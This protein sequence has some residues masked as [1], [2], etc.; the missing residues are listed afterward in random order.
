MTQKTFVAMALLCS[1][2]FAQSADISFFSTNATW[3]WLR[4][5]AEASSPDISS[6]RSNSF[7]DAAFADAPAPFWYGDVQP[8][9]TQLTDML[10]SYS[11]IFLRRT[12]VVT[13]VAE[14]SALRFGARVDDGYVV[15]INGNERLRVNVTGVAGD[16][17]TITTLAANA[18][19]PV[20]FDSYTFGSLGSYLVNGTNTIAIQ[21]FNTSLGSSDLVFDCSLDGV[22]IDTNPPVILSVTPPPGSS[23]NTLTQVVVQFSEPITSLSADDLNIS[24]V[25]ATAVS[26]S[27]N[28][29]T[30]TFAQPPAGTV[31]M[32]WTAGHSIT[33]LATPGNPFNEFAPGATWNYTLVDNVPPVIS[34]LFPGAD[35]TV[36]TLGQIQ[37]TFSETV[38]GVNA[39]DLLIN[40]SP[41]TNLVVLLNSVYLF[42]FPLQPSG[43][44]SV[45]WAGGHGIADVAA[46]PNAFAGGAWNYTVDPNANVSGVIINEINVSNQ[47][48]ARDENGEEQDWIELYNSG[49][50]A[51][52]LA[53]WSLSDDE[54]EPGRWVFPTRTMLP[55][56]YLVV[57]ASAKDRRAPT[58]TN[59]F[60]TNFKLAGDGEFLGLFTPDSPRQLASGFSPEFPEQRNDISYGRD[61]D[62]NYRYFSTPTFN[63][64]NGV[65]TVNGVVSRVHFS[66]ERG[67]FT[68]AFPLVLS[69][70]TRGATIRYTLDGS[71]PT[72]LRGI[73]Y[74]GPI[75]VNNSLFIRAGAFHED[76]L[77]SKITSHSFLF[78]QSAAIRSLP[79]LSI[80]TATNNLIGTNGIIGMYGGTG[81]PNNAWTPVNPGDFHNPTKKGIEWEKPNSVEYILPGDNSG[82][83]IDCG[84]R[85]QGSDWT[86]PRYQAGDKFS[87]RLYFRG[88]Y[89]PGDL[90]YQWFTDGIV[91]EFDQI[92]LRAGHN[93][94]S[95]PFLRDEL[96]RQLHA[97]MGQ[98]AVHGNWV[99]FF[100]NGVYKGYYN[101]C[102]RV[103]EG[104]LQSWHGGSN[105]W[106]V[107]TVG[108]VSQGDGDTVD[109]TSLR[110]YI[111]TQDA[112]QPAV[113]NEVLR[114]M[115]VANFID[116]LLVNTYAATWD[117][118]HNNWRAARERVP[119]GKWRF[120]VWD[121]EGAFGEFD[122]NNANSDSF[123]N[124]SINANGVTSPLLNGTAEI[125]VFYTRLRNSAEFRLMWADRV[126]KH[127]F[128]GGAM[129]DTNITQR[130]LQ[131][132]GELSQVIPG[133]NNN[134]LNSFIPLRRAVVFGQF[135]SYGLYASNAP[136]FNQHGSNVAAGFALTMTAPGGGTIYFTTNGLDPRVMYSGTVHGSAVAYSEP[137]TLNQSVLVKARTLNGGNWSA[138]TEANFAVGSRGVP[139]RITEISYNPFG[140]TAFE[141][142]ELQNIGSSPVDLSGMVF[143]GVTYAFANGTMLAAG[144]R[145]V[146]ASDVSPG[147]FA[148][149][150]PGVTVA[151]YFSGN[152]NN[153]G[154]RLALLDTFGNVITSVDFDDEGGWPAAADGT[155]YT[156]ENIN[157]YGDPDDPAN[158]RVSVA[159]LGT[160][161]AANASALSAAV[162]LNEVLAENI[163]AV[164]HAGTFPDY[165]ELAN[166]SG[167][168]IDL[169]GWSL[170][171]DGNARKFVFP[172]GTSIDGDGY[173]T[174]WC[175]AATNVTPG[176]HADFALGL[177]GDSLYLYDAATNLVDALSLGR[178]L[179]D[180][181]VGR[182]G[183]TWVL[184][185]PTTNAANIAAP[186]SPGSS[187]LINEFL[188]NAPSGF[189][190]W[191]EL[192]NNSA[193]PVALRGIFLSNTQTVHQITS[194]SF[195]P[196]FGYMQLFADEGVG[197]D[198]LDFKL[199]AA[200]GTIILY[201]A[202]GTE[203]NRLSYT[204]QAEGVTR[205]RLPDGT[206]TI[207]NF[208]GTA[209]PGAANYASTYTGPVLNEVLARNASAVTNSAGNAADYVE[210][211]N[212]GGSPFSLAGFS[213]GVDSATPGQWTFPPGS[214][215]GAGAYLLIWCDNARAASTNAGDYNTGRALNGESG[216][217]YLFNT[218]SQLVNFVEYGFQ[219]ENRAI[220]LVSSQWRL[221]TTNSP[222]V[223]NGTA[224]TLGAATALRFNEWLTSAADGPD[225]FEIYNSTNLPV[226]LSNLVLTDDPTSSGTNEFRVPALSFIG[227]NGFVQYLADAQ[228][229]EGRN[230][231]SF[232][233]DVLGDTLRLY[234][235]NGSNV[236]DTV[237]FGLLPPGVSQG[238][239]PDGVTN[240]IATFPG[241]ASPGASNYRLIPGVVINEVLSHATLPL[242]PAIE[243]HNVTGD[244][245]NI[246]GWFLSDSASNLKK[247]RLAGGTVIAPGGFITL[248][249][250]TF[251]T[252]PN[253]FTLDRALGGELWLSEANAETNLTGFRT[254]VS[255]GA[256]DNGVSFGRI[257]TGGAV[258]FV[259]Q[260]ARTLGAV[261]SGPLVGPVVIHEIMY[262]PTNVDVG[263]REFIEL[264]NVSGASVDLFDSALPANTWRVTDGVSFNFPTGVTLAAGGYALI[265]DFDPVANPTLLAQFRAFYSVSPA[266]PVFGPFLGQL[267]NAGETI[268]LRKP[269]LPSGAFVPYVLVDKI[270]YLDNAPWPSGQVDGG[271]HSLQRRVGTDYGNDAAN[272]I[273][274]APT[275]GGAN[276]SGVTAP[277]VITQSPANANVFLDSDVL[278]QAAATG[279]GP[280]RWQ[281]R[282][283]GVE[284]PGATNAALFL[285]SIRTEE[286]G[287]YDAFAYNAGGTVFS[288]PAQLNI[289]QP[290]FIAVPPPTFYQTNGG[291][292]VTFSVTA[293]GTPPFSYQWRFN[294]VDIPGA[295]SPTFSLTNLVL[296]QSAVY[297]AV[298][299]NIYGAA[300]ASVTLV[301]LIRPV[302]TNH[303][304]PQTV[305]Q[306]GNVTFA[307]VAGPEHPLAP[308]WYRWIRNGSS[309]ATTSVPVIVITNVQANATFRVGVTNAA[310]PAGV[311][312]PTSGSVALTVL[313]DVDGD[314]MSDAWETNYFGFVD[315]TNSAANALLDPDGDGMSN[316]DE[317][318]AGTNPTN[319]LSVLRLA[320]TTLNGGQLEF[321]A[322]SN[323]A[324]TIQYRTNIG[325]A[326][327]STVTNIAGQ[328]LI[329]TIQLN[330][331]NPLPSAER[332]F[333]VVTPQLP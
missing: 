60:H 154:E 177:N 73:T 252:P 161:G 245:L 79:A 17:V 218:S 78:N 303:I 104:F 141:F 9:G 85:V 294:D 290:A 187:L 298:V 181:S 135:N 12:F 47:S 39:A 142:I 256:A 34:Q 241:S 274:A 88:D 310:A 307:L 327:W 77:P 295:N 40:G 59:R 202:G 23:M 265:V 193:L 323:I 293:G 301:V 324:Y 211:F 190:D 333:R 136:V 170:T 165:V 55:G 261:N 268:E 311:F 38:T 76:Q 65:S 236:I 96:A 171:D 216:G 1:C 322:Q 296:S 208:V 145:L 308:L 20:P 321:V 5:T 144:A 315:T 158:W 200:G 138:L 2:L 275:A 260:T 203:V 195:I 56:E 297:S 223:A 191:I 242:E 53:G 172:P 270:S 289:V 283:N 100:L 159:I 249:G 302:I 62:G 130:Y 292:N 196:A 194:L 320:L 217:V 42:Q 35:A 198:H 284:L 215:I 125:P 72:M 182:I 317:Y 4:G 210:L 288:A 276:A 93:D 175:D 220:G 278:L 306:G 173:F 207:V 259:A 31:S 103:E 237:V 305:L 84:I 291:S 133:F 92:V 188:A 10:N 213:L 139:L 140:G 150:Y 114:R 70:E 312:S 33:D 264:H 148:V 287:S 225:W 326:P 219:V 43:S 314:G 253:A 255:F 281:W 75:N 37:V 152:L 51:V 120:Y 285:E 221:L 147:S 186:V 106:D 180:Q 332:Y 22:L 30:F 52:N 98:V 197:P 206:A 246:G 155:G 86:R 58:G 179:P 108:S 272:W 113:F 19:E 204:A 262:N 63:A 26:A 222:G 126:Q 226:D 94:I 156:L 167:G 50:G 258:D 82:F 280:I 8:G 89:S 122:G 250:A 112:T 257:Q 329:Q 176:L 119:T 61:A 214:S 243:L 247:L 101:P 41:A 224:T 123:I 32:T 229:D 166:T 87:Y 163:G 115:D 267:N 91:K 29:Y 121:A 109:W 205:G 325:F 309:F 102:E 14:L 168:S 13:N 81:P 44:V 279:L 254:R 319:A 95:N 153:A 199:A 54:D 21:V 57:W 127:Y 48:G 271:G 74:T 11:C 107:I 71:E 227:A 169:S 131:M 105:S 7:N 111:N 232:Q 174:V 116:Y 143:D 240:S 318:V 67:F 27:G 330:A 300:T 184:N 209:S 282:F 239:V 277:P 6:W 233:L 15:W 316:R 64:T 304:Q 231:V 162:R 151:G 263:A 328:S 124:R 266:V 157:P 183:G 149:A 69:C 299:T 68:A 230:H 90:D 129:T 228:P 164:N 313:P 110:N 137:V 134:I 3:R 46:V 25:G 234:S 97:D 16:P 132:R 273:G 269:S 83:Q 251:G 235:T 248:S 212:A 178:Q 24:G 128:N 146:I 189:P 28:F 238:R 45:A 286:S 118:P 49:S 80:Q 36:Q 185:T 244:A 331:P 160:P 201:D 99:N 117:W 192:Y 18:T 66:A